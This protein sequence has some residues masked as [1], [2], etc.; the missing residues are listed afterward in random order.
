VAGRHVEEFA[1][2][3]R[4]QAVRAFH[5]IGQF[6]DGG[7]ALDDGAVG[8]KPDALNQVCRLRTDV[9]PVGI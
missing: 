6:A 7:R 5:L 4:L 3:G 9:N 2:C 8:A 1:V